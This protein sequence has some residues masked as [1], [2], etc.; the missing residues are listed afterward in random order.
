MTELLTKTAWKAVVEDFKADLPAILKGE[1]PHMYPKNKENW[2]DYEPPLQE[3]LKYVCEYMGNG[4]TVNKIKDCK[5][6]NRNRK[7]NRA[8]KIFCY[9]AWKF[10]DKTIGQISQYLNRDTSTISVNNKDI[11]EKIREGDY[12]T[13]ST[14]QYVCS[15]LTKCESM[16]QG[17]AL[18]NGDKFISLPKEWEY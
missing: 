2:S 4:L 12:E 13:I 15:K 18:M 9:I 7:Y 11:L 6:S 3:V 16:K 1:D 10:T 5:S 14:I 17:L 8:R